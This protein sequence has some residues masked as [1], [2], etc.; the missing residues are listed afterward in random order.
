MNKISAV[1]ITKNEEKNIKECLDTLNWVDE[2]VVIDS[3]SDD[4]TIEVAKKYT[5][6]VYQNEWK[7]YSNQRNYGAN[8]ASNSWIISI[9]A[10]E[11]ISSELANEI[12]NTLKDPKHAAY[13][14]PM[15]NFV[16][17]R[18]MKHSGLDNQYHIR[19]YNKNFCKW[20]SVIHEDIETNGGTI[21][22]LENKMLHIAYKNVSQLIAKIDR[23]TDLESEKLFESGKKPNPISFIMYPPIIFL[24]KYFFN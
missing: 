24:Y 4:N 12:Q 21:T 13:N 1:I 11:R 15:Q 5:N 20:N 14:I 18:W 2:I 23:Y 16:F 10:D 19:L 9:D 7:G 6:K 17:N 8:L 22:K 3:Y